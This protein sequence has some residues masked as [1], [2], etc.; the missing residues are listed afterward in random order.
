M[1]K[2][3]K[4]KSSRRKFLKMGLTAGAATIAGAGLLTSKSKGKTSNSGEKIKLLNT[5]GKLVEVDKSHVQESGH[6]HMQVSKEEARIGMLGKRFIMV[7]DLAKCRNA[8]KCVESCQEHHQLKPSEE[9]MKVFLMRESEDTAPYWFPKPCFHCETPACVNVC[10]VGATFK[11]QDGIVL[12]DNER[13]IGCKF[14]MTACPYSSRIFFWEE[15]TE[16]EEM[17]EHD[18][19]PE[20]STPTKVGTVGKCDYCPDMVRQGILPHCVTA[21]P[22]GAIYYGDKNEDTVTNGEETTRFSDIIRDRAGYRYVE[23]LGTRPGCYYLP[24]VDRL[25]SVEKGYEDLPEGIKARYKNERAYIK[26]YKID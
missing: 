24:P 11:R 23:E 12:I 21:C 5:E 8:R 17:D 22:N 26:K 20:T 4:I 15:P 2:K 6:T 10:P 16:M 18:Y 25:F 9:Y 7:I 13:C 1:A 19:S 14:C 3:Q